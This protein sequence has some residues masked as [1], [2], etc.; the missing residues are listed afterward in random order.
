ME[1][2]DIEVPEIRLA[3]VL[4]ALSH[5]LDMTEGQPPGPLCALLLDWLADGRRIE[6]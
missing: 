4:S 6:A 1:A 2:T 5:A 3:E